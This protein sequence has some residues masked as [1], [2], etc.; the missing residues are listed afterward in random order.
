MT[1]AIPTGSAIHRRS[2]RR[3]PEP[4]LVVH[5]D[6]SIHPDKR[7]MAQATRTSSGWRVEGPDLV[8]DPKEWVEQLV[9]HA[10]DA[11]GPA[12]VGFDFP[13]GVPEAYAKAAGIASFTDH[14]ARLGAPPWDT[15]MDV[16]STADQISLHRPF[17][18]HAPGGTA[19]K[20]LIEGL[21]LF[22]GHQLLRRCERAQTY[23]PA[24]SP[25]FWTMGAKQVGKASISGWRD[26]VIPLLAKLADDVGIWPFGGT[27]AE[28]C[29]TRRVII[30]ETY[31]GDVYH[32]L[33]FPRG[34]WSKRTQSDRKARGA[35]VS[36][37][38]EV[39]PITLAASTRHAIADGF[40]AKPDGEDPFDAV[41]GLL[42]MLGT[43]ED[44][45]ADRLPAGWNAL[46]VEGWIFGQ[47]PGTEKQA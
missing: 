18:P 35:N 6:W 38:L 24:A 34:G 43:L 5:A 12:I 42:G 30:A 1:A 2:T 25:L 22:D 19:Q 21:G 8:P 23:R 31:P 20:H 7:W 14:L 40:G 17:Y 3:R 28:L 27:L 46:P 29:E 32:R 39:R 47:D 36:S 10:I 33:G 15:F 37:W 9:A 13:I 41:V 45:H 16:C 44:G 26:V 4:L 11:D